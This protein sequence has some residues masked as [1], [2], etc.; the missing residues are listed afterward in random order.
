MKTTFI[1]WKYYTLY[2]KLS[3]I[4]CLIFF[5]I[6]NGNRFYLIELTFVKV[7]KNTEKI[8]HFLFQLIKNDILLLQL[9]NYTTLQLIQLK[10]L[11]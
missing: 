11:I 5:L 3:P 8:E 2:K 9:Y 1:H 10:Q 6:I 7:E 4:I